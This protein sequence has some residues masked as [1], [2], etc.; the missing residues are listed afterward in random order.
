MCVGRG[1]PRAT[2]KDKLRHLPHRRTIE[3]LDTRNDGDFDALDME[4][5]LV[6]AL[7]VTRPACTSP[8]LP[9][10]APRLLVAL[11]EFKHKRDKKSVLCLI[12]PITPPDLDRPTA[13]VSVQQLQQ[14]RCKSQTNTSSDLI[15]HY[16][17]V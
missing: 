11:Q 15:S 16:R 8:L 4:R 7:S 1:L 12:K 6:R 14:N 5:A 13:S 10:S 2:T 9:H 17:K 3:Q